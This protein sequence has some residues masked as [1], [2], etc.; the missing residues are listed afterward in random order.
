MSSSPLG[1]VADPGISCGGLASAVSRVHK[2]VWGHS[3]QWGPGAE[4][5]DILA[6]KGQYL[7]N[8]WQV[9]CKRAL[10]VTTACNMYRAYIAVR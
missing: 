7:N 2:E 3:P 4:A 10:N 8:G 5:D 9:R 1:A 6:F